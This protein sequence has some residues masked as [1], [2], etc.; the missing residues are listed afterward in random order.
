MDSSLDLGW[1][2][3][4]TLATEGDIDSATSLSTVTLPEGLPGLKID[5]EPHQADSSA[6][7]S[8]KKCKAFKKSSR[9]QPK[10]LKTS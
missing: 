8:H 1:Q 4:W 7:P 10:A 5:D 6:L 3:L 9:C 2:E